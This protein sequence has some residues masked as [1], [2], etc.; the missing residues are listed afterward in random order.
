MEGVSN[1]NK[2][3]CRFIDRLGLD[4]DLIS[5]RFYDLNSVKN[6][7]ERGYTFEVIG[8]K[9]FK[10]R[11]DL[12]RLKSFILELNKEYIDLKN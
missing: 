2:E 11:S 12:L 7:E 10:I 8:E 1:L 9:I 6:D 3:F 5:T 4:L